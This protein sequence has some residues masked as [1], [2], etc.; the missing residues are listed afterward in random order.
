VSEALVELIV[1][2]VVV[3]LC[4]L[5]YALYRVAAGLLEHK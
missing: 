3:L 4:A 2:G 1:I 5:T